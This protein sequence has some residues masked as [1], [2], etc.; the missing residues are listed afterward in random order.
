MMLHLTARSP[1]AFAAATL[2][3]ALLLL[4]AAALAQASS[5]APPAAMSAP[6]PRV[7][8]RIKSLHAALKIT[9]AE[10][11]L[12][13]TVA[14]VMRGNAVTTGTLIEERAAKAKAMTAVDDLRSYAAIAASHAAG[15][16]KLESAFEPLYA[17]MPDNQKKLADAVF[18]RRPRPSTPKKKS[19]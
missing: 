1:G 2:L 11:P 13:Q 3:A 7:E 18:R 9:A 16:Q 19:G 8:A 12:W 14:D 15:V 5:S 4:P 17:A 6:S 10:E